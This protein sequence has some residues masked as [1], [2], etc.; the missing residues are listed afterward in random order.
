MNN[1]KVMRQFPQKFKYFSLNSCLHDIHFI[2]NYLLGPKKFSN[3]SFVAQGVVATVTI[4]AVSR[5]KRHFG[6]SYVSTPECTCP[7]ERILYQGTPN[8]RGSR[9]TFENDNFLKIARRRVSTRWKRFEINLMQTSAR[10][11]KVETRRNNDPR[12]IFEF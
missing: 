12:T 11:E 2:V 7:R 9:P 5:T 1:W 4:N 10:R 8:F 3:S 6:Q